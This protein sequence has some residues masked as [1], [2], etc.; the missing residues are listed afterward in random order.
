MAVDAQDTPLPR[1]EDPVEDG[2][3]GIEY[4]EECLPDLHGWRRCVEVY[5]DG[6]N[7]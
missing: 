5:F 3:G 2:W 6:T 1:P 7:S 4:F